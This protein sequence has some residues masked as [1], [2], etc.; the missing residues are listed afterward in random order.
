MMEAVEADVA[1]A[2]VAAAV[3]ELRDCAHAQRSAFHLTPHPYLPH[4]RDNALRVCVC[5]EDRWLGVV[6]NSWWAAWAVYTH[7]FIT[8]RSTPDGRFT[9]EW[10]SEP[11]R[12]EQG[13]QRHEDCGGAARCSTVRRGG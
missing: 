1:A 13:L 11:F 8:L 3:A 9:V 12:C 5:S 2:A 4:P 7:Y 6:H 10:V